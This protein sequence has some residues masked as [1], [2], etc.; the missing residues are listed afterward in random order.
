MAHK[1]TAEQ[2]KKYHQKYKEVYRENN[3]LRKGNCRR[4]MK[5]NPIA[6]KERLQTQ[7]EKK[8]KYRQRVKESISADTAANLVTEQKDDSPL[9][10][11]HK[12]QR[13]SRK[14]QKRSQKALENAKKSFQH[15]QTYSNCALSQPNR[16]QEDQGSSWLKVK[17]NGSKT[18]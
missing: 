14:S 1:S 11:A 18:F 16:K 12:D 15:W 3:S 5:A 7:R 4:K 6:N 8:Q 9:S 2:C 17:K 13:A 10:Q